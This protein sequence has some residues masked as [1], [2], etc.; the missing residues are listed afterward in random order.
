MASDRSIVIIG[1]GLA[2]AKAGA[3]GA[4]PHWAAPR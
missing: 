3:A 1:G 4:R 2:G